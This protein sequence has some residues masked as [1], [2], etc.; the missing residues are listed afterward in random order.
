MTKKIVFMAILMAAGIAHADGGDVKS[1]QQYMKDYG[2]LVKKMG[3]IIK[4]SDASSFPAAEF[5]TL[6]NNLNDIADE[7]WK[8]YTPSSRHEEDSEATD[9]VW[10]QPEKFQAAIDRF[11]SSVTKLNQAASTH[12]LDAVK[13]PFG[14]LGQ[15][16]KAC[17]KDF[18]AD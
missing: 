11:K 10:T 1:R 17:H 3:K 12:Q 13:A 5:Q 9:L 15:S 8:H 4:T 14:E 16:C 2:G 7:P 18:K 6:A